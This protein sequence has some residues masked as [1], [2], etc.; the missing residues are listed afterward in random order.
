MHHT[1]NYHMAQAR[2]ADLRNHAQ[3]DTLARAARGPGRRRRPGL[4]ARALR[5]P[6][7]LPGIT[8]AAQPGAAGDT[9]AG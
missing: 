9:P 5:R 8:Q 3:R 2:I 7:A 6:G 4:R 1:I